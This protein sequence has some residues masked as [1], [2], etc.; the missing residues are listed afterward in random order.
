MCSERATENPTLS[1]STAADRDEEPVLL[2][3]LLD[4]TP[5]DHNLVLNATKNHFV[6]RLFKYLHVSVCVACSI[7]Y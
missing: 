3:R 1:L 7:Y 4:N 6:L 2:V 5:S